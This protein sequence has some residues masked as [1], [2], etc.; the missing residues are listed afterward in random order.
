MIDERNNFDDLNDLFS[1]IHPDDLK[2][3]AAQDNTPELG[4]SISLHQHT[5]PTPGASRLAE[6]QELDAL[7]QIATDDAPGAA[8]VD[9]AL[10]LRLEEQM[11]RANQRREAA[12]RRLMRQKQKNLGKS[13]DL[14]ILFQ[15]L[16]LL[17][18]I[19]FEGWY[20]YLRSAKRT[21]NRQPIMVRAGILVGV[22]S[23]ILAGVGMIFAMEIQEYRAAHSGPF[24]AAALEDDYGISERDSLPD[25]N[26]PYDLMPIQLDRFRTSD[27]ILSAS[28]P[29]SLVNGC[30]LGIEP[31]RDYAWCQRTV[32]QTSSA[33]ARYYDI[34]RG[35]VDLA[36]ARFPGVQY[37]DQTMTEMLKYARQTGQVGNFAVEG[38]A[39]TDYF[40]S[41]NRGW[42]TFTW[43]R[44]PWVFSIAATSYDDLERAVEAFQY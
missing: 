39:E 23:L 34:K 27:T 19:V 13:F 16:F 6:K 12:R 41:Y 24:L 17:T 44:G 43:A 20:R 2:R 15:I 5:P 32:G 36:I 10:E 28:T 30:L 21:F 9:E 3:L 37:A 31:P 1:Q 8:F 18:A 26:N 33:S 38:I 14:V 25:T 7:R 40:Y 29:T 4:Q 35:F 42:V 11:I 22:A